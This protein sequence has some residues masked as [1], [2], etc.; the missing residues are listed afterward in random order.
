MFGLN[1][2]KASATLERAPASPSSVGVTTPARRIALLRSGRR[3]GPITRLITPW[4]IGETDI[5]KR[6]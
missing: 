2:L 4:D 6:E 3:R 1:Y 5:A